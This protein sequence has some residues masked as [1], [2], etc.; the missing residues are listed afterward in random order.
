MVPCQPTRSRLLLPVLTD[1]K[2]QPCVD[3]EPPGARPRVRAC[4]S[5]GGCVTSTACS[6][7][8]VRPAEH[9]GRGSAPRSSRIQET[10][11]TS[12]VVGERSRGVLPARRPR[13]RR[14]RRARQSSRRRVAAAAIGLSYARFATCARPP[15][16]RRCRGRGA[17]APVSTADKIAQLK[18]LGE[19]R[20][21]GVLPEFEFESEKRKL[22]D[23]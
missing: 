18:T 20:D 8:P 5:L 15:P 6:G 16:V 9:A 23:S 10:F 13:S 3:H 19:L 17:P 12:A 2:R 11:L 14:T 7:P 22:L 21:S 1:G 4:R